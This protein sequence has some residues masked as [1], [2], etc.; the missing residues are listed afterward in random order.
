MRR[1]GNGQSLSGVPYVHASDYWF[2]MISLV[3]PVIFTS[4]KIDVRGGNKLESNNSTSKLYPR[5]G[6]E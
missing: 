2:G 1:D 5:V 4:R 3:K 6:G